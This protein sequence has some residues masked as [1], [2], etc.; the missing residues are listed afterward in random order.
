MIKFKD[1][2]ESNSFHQELDEASVTLTHKVSGHTLFIKFDSKDVI[3]K[4]S[5]QGKTNPWLGSMCSLLIGKTLNQAI[6][7]NDKSWEEAF[8]EDQ[9]FWDYQQEVAEDFLNRPL[10]LLHGTLDVFRGREYLY[11]ETSA[12]ICRCFGIRESDILEHLQK[13]ETPTLESL[14]GETKAGMGCR[15]CVPQLKRWVALHDQKNHKHYYKDKAISEWLLEIDYMLS[16]FPESQD[17]NMELMGM[18]GKQVQIS[19]DKKVSQ[20]EEEEVAKRLQGFL[21]AALDPELAFFLRA[22]RH[23]SKAKG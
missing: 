21:G 18:K 4:M 19:F 1:F 12:L 23:F 16:C 20:R 8:R 9:A 2:F 14:S 13:N 3:L 10:E 15:T 17:W 7:F 22:A 11:Q 6:A 5:Y